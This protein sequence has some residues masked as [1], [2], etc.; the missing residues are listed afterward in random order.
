MGSSVPQRND[1][2]LDD[3]AVPVG[4]LTAS[5]AA[6]S[7]FDSVERLNI[8]VAGFRVCIRI[9]G[10]ELA[11]ALS[12][13]LRHLPCTDGVDAADLHI[14]VWDAR[15]AAVESCTRQ[16]GTRPAILLKASRSNR[17][18]GETRDH[19][20]LWLDRSRN[21]IVGWFDTPERLDLDE[22]ARPFHKLLSAWLEERGVQFLH[23]GLVSCDGKG[24]LFVGNGGAGKSTAS[25]ACLRSGMDYL[26]DD[27]IG[28]GRTETGCVGYGVYGSCL[29]NV[30]H[31]GRF[32]DLKA[33]A[34]APHHP[35]ED[36][37]VVFL[38]DA[39]PG[40]MRSQV[41]IAA[42]LLPRVADTVATR[43]RRASKAEA[44]MA[45]AP[46]SVMFLPRPSR[47]AFERI[48]ELVETLPCFWLEL[49]RDVARIPTAVRSLAAQ[50]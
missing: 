12:A 38:A 13:S 16:A 23:A 49:G 29:L 41:P 27:F 7:R 17:F 15:D 45:I 1:Q 26:G 35:H 50:L 42:L 34:H 46:T 47:S 33:I 22:R 4:R 2:I 39:F 18:V 11:R 24:L 20:E 48:V 43:V 6:A 3:E 30:D 25:I 31:I 40:A 21:R 14:D 10:A 44:L 28:F 5:F 9:V 32:P 36:K 8:V 19:T 37:D